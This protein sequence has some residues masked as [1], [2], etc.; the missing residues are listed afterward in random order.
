MSAEIQKALIQALTQLPSNE[1]SYHVYHFVTKPVLCKYPIELNLSGTFR[2]SSK[3]HRLILVAHESNNEKP[4][5]VCG[6]EAMEYKM[7][8]TDAAPSLAYVS[9]IDTTGYKAPTS[10]TAT[11]IKSYLSSLAE[12]T[13]H[14]FARAQPQYLF[15]ESAKNVSKHAQS[16]RGLIAWWLRVISDTPFSTTVDAWWNVPGVDDQ[17]SAKLEIRVTHNIESSLVKWHYGYPFDDSA[18]AKSVIPNFPDDAKARLLK[19]Y[20]SYDKDDSEDDDDDE[21]EE[22]EEEV[23]EED[24]GESDSELQGVVRSNEGSSERP[25]NKS[26]APEESSSDDDGDTAQSNK[27]KKNIKDLIDN[28]DPH[29]MTVREFWQL[30]SIGEECGAGKVTGLFIIRCG[31]VASVDN[32]SLPTPIMINSEQFTEIWN[33]LMSLDFSTK[34]NNLESTL[35]LGSAI[36]ESLQ[37]SSY[38][39][40]KVVPTGQAVEKTLKRPLQE[41][42]QSIPAV[43]VLGGSFI[44]RKRT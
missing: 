44:K 19:S 22:E 41:V 13:I 38:T 35:S 14:I 24:D 6:L 17:D 10:V 23:Q 28:N 30:L 5:L 40:T 25:R 36:A 39:P 32:T 37:N 29:S 12:C 34:E 1:G 11:L 3:I 42:K 21:E 33:K 7:K 2:Q 16:D 15:P 8:T 27:S 9:K 4:A 43:N 31:P 20:A 26:P 18:D